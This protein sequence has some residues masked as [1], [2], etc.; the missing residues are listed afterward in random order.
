MKKILGFG[1][2]KRR[3]MQMNTSN[4]P[5]K[6]NGIDLRI[7]NLLQENLRRSCKKVADELGIAVGMA[8]SHIKS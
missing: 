2:S 7:V 1:G 8:Y 6:L 5:R 4:R 3:E